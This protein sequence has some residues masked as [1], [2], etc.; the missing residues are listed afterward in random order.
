MRSLRWEKLIEPELTSED[1]FKVLNKF[2]I[3]SS[4]DLVLSESSL[5]K[6]LFTKGF[7]VMILRKGLAKR[8]EALKYGVSIETSLPNSLAFKK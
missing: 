4:R 8:D 2:D 1:G 7:M 3:M 6:N 5:K